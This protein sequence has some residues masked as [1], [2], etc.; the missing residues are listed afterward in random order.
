MLVSPGGVWNPEA[1]SP[2]RSLA[3]FPRIYPL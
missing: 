3:G 1:R 2:A